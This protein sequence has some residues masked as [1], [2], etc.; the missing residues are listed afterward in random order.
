MVLVETAMRSGGG[1]GAMFDRIASRYDLL[2][3]LNSFGADGRWRRIAAEALELDRVGDA[4]RVLDVASGTGDLAIA[5]ARRYPGA[6]VQGIDPSSGMTAIGRRKVERSGLG[7]RIRLEEG[8]AL[9]LAF[10]DDSFDAVTIA[11]G[12]RNIPNRER[13][14]GEIAR[15]TRPGGLVAVLELGEPSGGLLGVLPRFHIRFVVPLIGALLAGA[16]EYRYLEQS[17]RAFPP[18][19][20]FV[21]T[22]TGAGL[23]SIE[24]RSLTFGA[25]NLFLGRPAGEKTVA[26]AG[27]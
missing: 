18:V 21:R 7:S 3:R 22:M 14:L 4:P 17:I 2:N 24:T 23:E 16:S 5:V 11:F 26:G 15:V 19:T 8:D 10:A 20:E 9:N 1:S 25:C 12:I 13:A 6:T 27:A